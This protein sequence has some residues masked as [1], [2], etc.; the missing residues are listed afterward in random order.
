MTR[1]PF[2]GSSTTASAVN[3]RVTVTSNNDI[4]IG[5][6]IS[7]QSGTNS[8]LG[9]VAK[10]DMIVAYWSPS[11]LTWSAATT[12]QGGQW[13]DTCGEFGYKCG[14]HTSMTFNGSTAT[15]QGRSMS[16]FNSRTYNYDSTLLWLDPP[17]YPTIQDPYTILFQRE[18]TPT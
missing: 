13:T 15:D 16:M 6:N 3:G 2:I 5:N 17:W 9:L 4:V 10:N 11:T 14:S 1:T 7:Y 18:L 8:V 12:T